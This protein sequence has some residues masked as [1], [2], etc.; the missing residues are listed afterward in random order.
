MVEAEEGLCR[1]A[2][3]QPRPRAR[4]RV[5]RER[6]QGTV[7]EP[8]PAGGVGPRRGQARRGLQMHVR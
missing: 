3:R 4:R 2:R 6:A 1:R 8:D 5:A 7:V